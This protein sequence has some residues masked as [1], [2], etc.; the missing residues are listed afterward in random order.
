MPV[1]DGQSEL[2]FINMGNEQPC[3]ITC[4][5]CGETGHITNDCPR[6]SEQPTQQQAQ[7]AQQQAQGTNLCM[8][9]SEEGHDANG[10]FSFSQSATQPIP[11]T[12]IL[13][14]NQSMVD[15]FCNSM[16]LKNI[17]KSTT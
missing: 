9:G 7:G 2:A 10:G 14:N 15:L 6:R 5:N 1:G 16:L 8:H 3:Q 11:A 17:Q 12:W 4:Y 13:L